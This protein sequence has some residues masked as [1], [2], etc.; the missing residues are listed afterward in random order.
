MYWSPRDTGLSDNTLIYLLS[1]KR[2]E[3]A[4]PSREGCLNDDER[5][6]VSEASRTEGPIVERV[7]SVFMKKRPILLNAEYPS[8]I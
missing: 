8:V 1:Q 4:E 3:A 5:Q 2:R 7:E 6:Q